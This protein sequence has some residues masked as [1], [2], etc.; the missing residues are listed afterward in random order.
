MTNTI[1][2]ILM[3]IELANKVAGHIPKH[4]WKM[5]VIMLI[6]LHTQVIQRISSCQINILLISTIER[7]VYFDT[8]HMFTHTWHCINSSDRDF[9]CSSKAILRSSDILE[10]KKASWQPTLLQTRR[11]K[12][13]LEESLGYVSSIA[14]FRHR[15]QLALFSCLTLA[16]TRFSII[17]DL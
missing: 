3:L 1:L 17:A 6:W 12:Q 8:R 14:E 5:H 13:H 10:L 2:I 15:S 16:T 11:E 9:T 7:L 4:L